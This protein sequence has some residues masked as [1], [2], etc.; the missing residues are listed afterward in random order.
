MKMGVSREVS[1]P[2]VY[3]ETC[4]RGTGLFRFI[5]GVEK[6]KVDAAIVET[7]IKAESFL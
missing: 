2:L 6:L 5:M 7:L 4:V 1:L 3:G